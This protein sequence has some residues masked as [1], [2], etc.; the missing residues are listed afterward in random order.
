MVRLRLRW[1]VHPTIFCEKRPSEKII[2]RAFYVKHSFD[3]VATRGLYSIVFIEKFSILA[4][5]F[6]SK[7]CFPC[8]FTS[9]AGIRWKNSLERGE[10]ESYRNGEA[11]SFIIRKQWTIKD[12]LDRWGEIELVDSRLDGKLWF[13][14]G[15]PRLILPPRLS[16]KRR[17][18]NGIAVKSS[19]PPKRRA[20]RSLGVTTD[21]DPSTRSPFFLPIFHV[22]ETN[23]RRSPILESPLRSPAFLEPRQSVRVARLD[24]RSF[25]RAGIC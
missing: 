23:D 8:R 18:R 13:L 19:F 21:R 17:G 24:L 3:I 5:A 20:Y 15:A 2:L 22:R 25:C 7:Q 4:L 16:Q 11:Y 10:R 12:I 6:T 14:Y 1:R 9:N